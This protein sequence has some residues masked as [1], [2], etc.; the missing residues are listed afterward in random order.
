MDGVVNSDARRLGKL[1]LG[2]GA[3]LSFA[4]VRGEAGRPC[5]LAER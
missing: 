4:Q 1:D 3:G 5:G 2:A